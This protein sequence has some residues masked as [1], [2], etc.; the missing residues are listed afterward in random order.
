MPYKAR[1]GDAGQATAASVVTSGHGRARRG[2]P[3]GP[4]GERLPD[5]D[6]GE[7][8]V[9]PEGGGGGQDDIWGKRRRRAP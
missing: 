1:H 8:E 2:D 6:D 3:Q 7:R 9:N 4:C 5:D